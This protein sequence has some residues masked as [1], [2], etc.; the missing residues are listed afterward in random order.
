MKYFLFTFLFISSLLNAQGLHYWKLDE[1][2]SPYID[3]YGNANGVCGIDCPSSD[4]GQVNNTQ[5]FDG[6]N[7][8]I[9]VIDDGTFDWS[10]NDS[11]TIEFWMKPNDTNN[12]Q[13]ITGRY[14]GS[15][16]TASWWIGREGSKV[17]VFL[18]GLNLISSA[19]IDISGD[20]WTHIA[21]VRNSSG[22]QILYV[23]GGEDNRTN[24]SASDY[25]GDELLNIG[26][27]YDGYH[28]DGALD[29]IAIFN[30]ALSDVNITGD[31]RGSVDIRPQ[32]Q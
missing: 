21:V 23:N 16:G 15:S 29:E 9:N 3:T 32:S 10:V 30:S 22:D 24:V 4:E 11:F 7:D 31:H 6:I 1:V 28:F 13:V 17:K 20:T 14:Q 18:G 27:F 26:W 8:E 2:T 12:L 19:N 25:S 5:V